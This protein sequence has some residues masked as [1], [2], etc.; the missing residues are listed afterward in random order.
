LPVITR[1]AACGR[2]RPLPLPPRPTRRRNAR[3][4]PCPCPPLTAAF[5]R[6]LIAL[7]VAGLAFLTWRLANVVLLGF[8]GVLVAVLLRHL[9]QLLSRWTPLPVGASLAV[10][11]LGLVLLAVLFVRS[12]GP[13]VAAQFE[14]LWQALPQVRLLIDDVGSKHVRDDALAP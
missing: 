11:I 13:Q 12:V 5:A 10:V 6:W 8:G 2:D 3:G 1:S 9:A 7:L 4:L 14:Q